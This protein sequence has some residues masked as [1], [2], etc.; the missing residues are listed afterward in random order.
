MATDLRDETSV[1][2]EWLPH[3][4]VEPIDF[5]A[6]EDGDADE[7][8]WV[9]VADEDEPFSIAWVRALVAGTVAS[10]ALHLWLIATM[11]GMEFD[12]PSTSA[13]PA[14]VAEMKTEPPEPPPKPEEQVEFHLA[15][16]NDRDVPL[17]Q[18]VTATSTGLVHSDMPQLDSPPER[19][20]NLVPTEMRRPAFDIPEGWEVNEKI[21]VRGTIG[22]GLLHI[23]S[24]MDRVTREI[25][26][27]LA[28]RKLLVVWMLDASESLLKQRQAI[29]KRL[30]RVYGELGALEK[31]G[32]VND[33]QGSLLSAVV[34][35]G[36]GLH[37]V[38]KS[39]TSD[40]PTIRE[41]IAK[42]PTDPSGVENIFG[43]ILAVMNRWHEYRT[44]QGR[45]ILL[46]VV[47]D[48]SGDDFALHEP[49]IAHCR[50]YG[51][52]AYVVGPLAVFGRRQGLVPYRAPEDGKTY[53]LPVDLGP[54]TPMYENV[55]LPFWF[56]GPQY[57]YLSSGFP[58]YALARLVTETGGVYFS[59][60][61]L[62]MSGLTPLGTFAPEALHQ[63]QPDYRFGT[64]DQYLADLRQHP[65]RYAVVTAARF[66][67]ENPPE[68]TPDLNL[69]V[70]PQDFRQ[71]ATDAQKTVAKSHYMLDQILAAFP[72]DAERLLETE[73]SPRWR[74]AFCLAYGRLLAQ[75]VRCLEYNA[76]LAE[77]KGGLSPEQVGRKANQWVFHASEQLNYATTA[78][79][80]ART[81]TA[82]LERVVQ[83][84]PGTPW[85]LLAG[86]E[87]DHPLGMRVELRY[88]PPPPP[89]S[90]ATQTAGKPKPR[91]LL[92]PEKKPPQPPPKPQPKPQPPR[93]PKL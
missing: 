54:E 5:D 27:N 79:K 17:R 36:Q 85:A 3:A 52:K 41:A 49:A 65:L 45:R 33:L 55:R 9:L 20:L 75:K 66:S 64:Q 84:A 51:A 69:R 43:A 90:R 6:F 87:L 74:M 77:M 67:R 56:A 89:P 30:D 46:I 80:T 18:V 82:L 29:A 7:L 15:D 70:T 58:P 83:E 91:L 48:E 59:T 2:D 25:A 72:P 60:N 28:E 14:L 92:A 63:F 47:T 68:G 44:T 81:A 35:Y 86:R 37:Y 76:A 26:D 32:Q 50:R 10:V 88:I 42:A 39:P 61:T 22:E 8:P 31:D 57:D 19:V 12:L 13:E 16:P 62:T 71:K 73:S 1:E 21:V 4:A 38:T 24:A 78:Q 23:N 53:Q 34:C 40:F 93:L 11:S